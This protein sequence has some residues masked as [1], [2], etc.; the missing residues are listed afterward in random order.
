VE[1]WNR[2]PL[3]TVLGNIDRTGGS[4]TATCA[5]GRGE[6]FV[7]KSDHFMDE[8]LFGKLKSNWPQIV[9][10]AE[11]RNFSLILCRSGPNP[12]VWLHHLSTPMLRTDYLPG[13]HDVISWA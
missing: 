5:D 10:P 6:W 9:P 2:P 4:V 11:T 3:S 7:L 1:V 13:C 12:G 8:L